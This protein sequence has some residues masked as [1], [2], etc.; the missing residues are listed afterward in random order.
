VKL[1]DSYRSGD[2]SS[3]DTSALQ[4]QQQQQQWLPTWLKIVLPLVIFL[5]V[6][7]I[8]CNME[9]AYTPPALDD[10]M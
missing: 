3:V 5:V 1:T 6:Y 8:V 4:Q 7:L 9:P 10:S 2:R